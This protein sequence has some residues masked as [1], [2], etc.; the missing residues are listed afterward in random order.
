LEPS[1]DLTWEEFVGIVD[2]FPRLER[3]VLHGI[4]EPLLNRNLSR[5][6]RYLKE[7][8]GSYVLFNSN[9]IALTIARARDLIVSGLDEYRVSFDAASPETY[10]KVRGI[11]AFAKVVRN[12]TGL[13][14]ELERNSN[15]GPRVSLWFTGMRDNLA[16]LPDLIRMAARAGVPEVYLQRL[17]YFGVGMAQAEQSIYAYP[18]ADER[19]IVHECARLAGDLGVKFNGSGAMS[20]LEHFDGAPAREHERPWSGCGRPWRL[21]YITSHGNVLPCCIAPFSSKHYQGIVLGN[22][23]ATPF[24]EIWNGARYHIF[25]ERLASDAPPD[26]CEGCGLRWSL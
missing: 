15:R 20:P 12:L 9:A 4:G 24:Q 7:Q 17:V 21:S 23:F 13:M 8:R 1:K 5:F 26:P 6:I 14:Q 18:T 3:V 22:I 2:Q 16:E 25:R 19:A 10:L 11:P